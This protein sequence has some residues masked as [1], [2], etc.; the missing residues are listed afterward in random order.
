M[1]QAPA[2]LFDG[3]ADAA[4]T[5]AL[6]H[7]AAVPMDGDFM[8]FFA[9]ALAARGHRVARF[10]FPYMEKRRADGR[11]RPPDRPDVLL[12]TWRA[13]V[14]HLDAKGLVIGGKS[15]GGRIASMIADETGVCG[16][17][18]LGYPFHAQGKP[19]NVRVA[20]L[21]HL[22]TPT[23]ILQGAR[24]ALGSQ[25]EVARYPLSPAITV[26]WLEDGDHSFV[27][28]KASGRTR[29]DNWSEAATAFGAF[30]DT[31]AG[32]QATPVP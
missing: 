6:A 22:Q 9:E 4:M 14:A 18:A 29:E 19:E 20:H 32:A 27:P 24:D 1:S 3:P 10:E 28:R 16:L 17:V 25:A 31:L 7:G 2:F 23:L 12:D 30:V 13:V 8:T 15:L 5:V 26:H 11:N 21:E